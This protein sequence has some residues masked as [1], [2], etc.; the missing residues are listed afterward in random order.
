MPPSSA[1]RLKHLSQ[2]RRPLVGRTIALL[3]TFSALLIGILG[4]SLWTA[5][6][7]QLTQT[8]ASTSNMARALAA[9]AETSFKI[10]DAIL[11]ETV[12][13]VEHDGVA[14]AA[15]ERLHQ[16]FLHIVAHSAEV[17]GLFVYG[18]D[19]SWQANALP[20][21]VQANNADRDYFRYHQTHTGRG[22]H[23]GKPVRSR[24]SGVMV[25]PVSRRIDRPDGSFGG[26]ALVTLDLGFFGRFYDRFDVGRGGTI[27]LALDDGTL[28]YRRPFKESL[29]GTDI[30]RGPV[31]QMM[32]STG[33]VGTAMLKSGIDGVER[34]FSYHHLDGYPLMVASAQSRD[35]I[36]AHWRSTVVRMSCV[37]AFAIAM[38]I[39]GGRRMVRQIRVR[40]HL[41]DELRRAGAALE[42]HNQ[43]LKALAESDGLTG[44]A[45]RRLFEETLGRELGR[46]RRGGAAFAL[47]MCDV[48]FFKKYNDRYGHV[49]GDDCLRKVAAAIGAG[50][51]RPG[52]LAARYGGEEFALILPDTSLAGAMTVA[53]AIRSAVAALALEHADS[54]TGK[55]SISLGVVAGAAGTEPDGAWVEAADRL[56]YDAKASGRDRVAAR[57]GLMLAIA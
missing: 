32:R 33:P 50:A 49:A 3:A 26:V 25:I 45:N 37:V 38:L 55:V 40:E 30:S 5:R 11:A 8:A 53:E 43:S 28:I 44:L 9:Q 48:D 20:N 27:A 16:R 35:E 14:G 54:P 41:E 13:R 18:A 24:S 22:T 10:A 34:L 56:L 17:H 46:A 19:G 7:G 12:E 29:V 52:D 1:P 36:L 23:I 47:I 21:P 51:R 57:E 15:G 6:Q 2:I 42:Q 31:F 4:W 39:W